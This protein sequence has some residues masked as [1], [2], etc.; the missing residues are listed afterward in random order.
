VDGVAAGRVD[1][2][3]ERAF[4]LVFRL[5]ANAEPWWHGDSAVAHMPAVGGA[6]AVRRAF[7]SRYLTKGSVLGQHFCVTFAPLT[8]RQYLRCIEVCL[9]AQESILPMP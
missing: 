4:M 9:R 2:T 8:S 1:Q 5:S 6:P 3:L 7:R